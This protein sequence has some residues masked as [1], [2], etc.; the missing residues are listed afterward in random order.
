MRLRQGVRGLLLV[1]CPAA[2]V[3]SVLSGSP[4]TARPAEVSGPDYEMPFPCAE[5]WT[6]ST[7]ANH[8]PSTRSIDFNRPGDLGDIMVASAPGVVSRVA[9]TGSTSYGQYVVVDHG[10]S[11]STLYA[12]LRSVWVT[13]G[14]RVDQ[15]RILGLVGESGGVTG[16]HLHFEERLGGQVRQ[17][18][19]H[20]SLYPS[21]TTDASA[22]CPDVPLVGDWDDD[23]VD[24][25]AVFRRG[26]ATGVF[27]LYRAD[28]PSEVIAFGRSSDTPVA[29]DWDGDGRTDVG[30]RRTG[31]RIFLLRN[32]DGTSTSIRLGLRQDVPVTGDWNGDGTT[33]VGV[34]RPSEGTFR[35][36]KGHGATEI[37][38][39]GSAGSEPVAG[40]WNGDGTSDVGVFDPSTASFTLRITTRDGTP[41]FTTVAF[42]SG[43]DIP[44]AGDWNGDGVT[45][46]GAWTP[47][48]ATY[49]LRTAPKTSR[50]TATVT[51]QKFGNRRR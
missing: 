44:V 32:A 27:R 45:D 12:H 31:Q 15:G 25:V 23:Q 47:S 49:A 11:H 8:K 14:Q 4:A 42:G 26:P 13:P 19:L 43:T 1:A 50:T 37:I 51:T 30:V 40:D 20:R 7:R 28:A 46:V 41:W 33:D 5:Q 17:A 34:W 36:R 10:N 6:G 9:D 48:T 3:A 29:G 21:G 39:L 2:L 18:Y 24:E 38:T 35:L 16:P 22:N